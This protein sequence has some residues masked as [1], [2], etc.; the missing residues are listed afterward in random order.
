[1]LNKFLLTS[2]SNEKYRLRRDDRNLNFVFLKKDH[3]L[4][5]LLSHNS[6]YFTRGGG[7]FVQIHPRNHP[8]NFLTLLPLP[9]QIQPTVKGPVAFDFLCKEEKQNKTKVAVYHKTQHRKAQTMALRL[10]SQFLKPAKAPL[11]PG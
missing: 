4:H 6:F 2:Y 7:V 5:L 8:L 11:L 10:S 3:T 9:H 1:M